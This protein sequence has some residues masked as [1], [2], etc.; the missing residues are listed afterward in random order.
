[1]R[2]GISFNKKKGNE[3]N[4]IRIKI[5]GIAHSSFI[6]GSKI[7]NYRLSETVLSAMVIIG[8]ISQISDSRTMI[9]VLMGQPEGEGKSMIG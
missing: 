6:V 2:I 1:V 7:S 8:M 4:G 3:K 9:D 5:I